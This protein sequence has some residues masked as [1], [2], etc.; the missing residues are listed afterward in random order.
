[1]IEQQKWIEIIERPSADASL[2][3]DPRAFDDRL[4][5]DDLLDFSLN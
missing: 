3:L 5:L 4:G 2:E 1:M